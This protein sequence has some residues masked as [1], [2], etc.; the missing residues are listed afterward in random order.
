VRANLTTCAEGEDDVRFF[1]LARHAL[2]E[3]LRIIGTLRGQKVLVPEFICRDLLAAI[4]AIGAEPVL[5]PVARSLAP[6][7]LPHLPD[8]KAVLAVNYFGF[9]QDLAV[10]RSYC[11]AHGTFLIEDNAH[12][13][14]SRDTEGN[15]LGTR[16]DLGIVSL[17]KT[18]ALP[19]GGALLVNRHEWLDR[20]E[21]PLPCRNDRLPAS[22]TVKRT[23]GRIQNATGVGVRTLGECAVR[24]YRRLRTG[25]A[26]PVSV[27]EEE[28]RMPGE[29]A[30]HCESLNIL[31]RIDPAREVERRR[32]LYEEFQRRTRGLD[33]EPVFDRLPAGAAPYGYPFRADP[34]SAAL[35]SR[36]AGKRGF[37]CAY[38]PDLPAAVTSTAPAHYRNVWWVNFLC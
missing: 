18:F 7:S 28:F 27:P 37:D 15:L 12:G 20:L 3:A 8:I 4:H 33:I 31:R 21:A 17:R 25:H 23:L 29:A 19:D 9:P 22:Y 30:I 34:S 5:F 38:W 13:Y 6:Q 14:L 32:R 35:V 10:F 11:A 1:R 16:G 26:V 36:I 2:H 24:S